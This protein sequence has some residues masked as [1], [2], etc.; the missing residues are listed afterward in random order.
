M[1]LDFVLTTKRAGHLINQWE[2]RTQSNLFVIMENSAGIF[3]YDG[4]TTAGT[5][6]FLYGETDSFEN[7][8]KFCNN[9]L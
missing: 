1:K 7:A 2:A 6:R 4:Y 8:V 5:D 9:S 3:Y